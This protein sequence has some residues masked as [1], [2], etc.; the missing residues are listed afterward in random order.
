MAYK[1]QHFRKIYHN[2]GIFEINDKIRKLVKD[3][4]EEK[5]STHVCGYGYIDPNKGLMIEL[6]DLGKFGK[7]RYTSKKKLTDKSLSLPFSDVSDVLLS[8]YLQIP[9]EYIGKI[10]TLMAFNGSEQLEKTRQKEELDEFRDEQ[11][12][13]RLSVKLFKEGLEPEIVLTEIRDMTKQIYT[14]IL[15]QT[16]KQP[17]GL[18]KG[19]IITFTIANGGNRFHLVADLRADKSEELDLE[20]QFVFK[21]KINTKRESFSEDV[22]FSIGRSD[23]FNFALYKNKVAPIQNVRIYNRTLDPL[24]NLLIRVTSDCD[25]F[26]PCEIKIPFIQ[27]KGEYKRDIAPAIHNNP[28]MD[29]TESIRANFKIELL[30]DETKEE[31]CPPI[32]WVMDVLTYEQWPGDD[33]IAYLTAF[34]IPNHKYISELRSIASNYLKQHNLDPSLEGYQTNKQNGDPN[35]VRELAAACYAAVQKKDISYN[36]PPASFGKGQRIRTVD[37][38]LEERQGTCMDMTL[39]YASLL[40]SIDLHS[41][42]VLKKG[43]IFIGV[44]LLEKAKLPDP[45]VTNGNILLHDP[46]LF[47]IE[48]TKMCSHMNCSFEE[49]E[50]IARNNLIK[51]INNDEFQ[52]GVDV[53]SVRK[54]YS[55]LPVNSRKS[56]MQVILVED[57][58]DKVLTPPPSPGEYSFFDVYEP[59]KANGPTNKIDLWESKLINLSSS[60][61]L[62]NIGKWQGIQSEIYDQNKNNPDALRYLSTAYKFHVV[63]D[64]S[65]IIPLISCYLPEIEDALADGEEFDIHKQPFYPIDDSKAIYFKYA[66]DQSNLFEEP[67]WNAIGF[68]SPEFFRTEARS[69]RLY[70]LCHPDDLNKNLKNIYRKAREGEREYGMNSLYLALGVLRWFELE[71]EVCRTPLY[72][73]LI[74][75]PVDIEL[76]PG[77]L[78]YSL[79]QRTGKSHFNIALLEKLR[80]QYGLAIS[81]LDPL[82]VDDHGLDVA[83]IFAMVRGAIKELRGWDV[84]ETASIGIF[85]LKNIFMWNDIHTARNLL[86]NNKVIRSLIK[87]RVDWDTEKPHEPSDDYMTFVTLP[88]DA[89]QL[90]AIDYAGRGNTFVLHGP[91]GTGKSQTIAGMIGNALANHKTVLF[92]AQKETAL[93]VVQ[94]RLIADLG[95][96]DYCLALHS[97]SKISSILEQFE[98]TIAKKGFLNLSKFQGDAEKTNAL[99]KK[100]DI[101]RE[102]LHKKQHCGLTLHQLIDQYCCEDKNAPYITFHRENTENLDQETM[103]RQIPLIDQLISVRNG[104]D[105]AALTLL[106][107]IGISD[108]DGNV[109]SEINRMAEQY[110][111]A[112][113]EVIETG[114]QTSEILHQ[115]SP[116]TATDLILLSKTISEI[117]QLESIGSRFPD[118]SSIDHEAAIQ[119]YTNREK[120]EKQ[121]GEL[122]KVWTPEFLKKK[123]SIFRDKLASAQKGIF[124]KITGNNVRKVIKELE[125]YSH[126][127]LNEFEVPGLLDQVEAFQQ[128]EICIENNK[129]QLSR[130]TLDL[131]V[132]F[133][134][135]SAF[136]QVYQQACEYQQREK[137][138]TGGRN[139]ADLRN[140]PQTA[141]SFRSFAVAY[142][143]YLETKQKF[144]ETLKR[145]ETKRNTDTLSDEISL[146]R[147]ILINRN[148]VRKA[149]LYNQYRA[150]CIDAGLEPVVAAYENGMDDPDTLKTAYRKGLYYSLIQGIINSDTVMTHFMGSKFNNDIEH[151][152]EIDSEFCKKTIKELHRR[153]SNNL[154]SPLESHEIARQ[155]TTLQKAIKRGSRG[156]AL[157]QLFEQIPDILFRIFPCMLMC[158]ETVAQYLPQQNDLFDLVIFDE[159]S[160]METCDA[161]G[162]LYRGKDAVIVGDP[163]QMTPTRFFAGSGSQVVNPDIEDLGSI[164][165]EV[166]AI[167]IPSRFLKWHYRSAHESLIA[168]SNKNFYKNGMFTFPSADDR[169]RKIRLVPVKSNYKESVNKNEAIEIVKEILH[170]FTDPNTP[171]DHMYGV[172]AF[173]EQQQKQI[174]DLLQKQCNENRALHEW[175]HSMP[176]GKHE[177]VEVKPLEKVQGDEWDT[178][179]FSITF[180]PD[181]KGVVRQ[182]FGPINKD[183][184]G[185]RLNVA[186]SRARKEMLVYTGMRSSDIKTDKAPDGVVAFHDFLKFV[187]DL[188][189]DQQINENVGQKNKRNSETS[190]IVKQLCEVLETNGFACVP[191]IGSSDFRI[192]I[193]VLNPYDTTR[194]LLGIML[195]GDTYRMTENTKDREIAQKNLLEK[196]RGWK[197]F[198]IWALDWWDDREFVIEQLLTKLEKLKAAAAE[199]ASHDQPAQEERTSDDPHLDAELER[200]SEEVSAELKAEEER[201]ES[202]ASGAEAADDHKEI[203]EPPTVPEPEPE[204]ETAVPD[205]EPD[206]EPEAEP[207]PEQRS[208]PEAASGPVTAHEPGTSPISEPRQESEPASQEKDAP[209][210]D[211]DTERS[212]P[213]NSEE[214][215]RESGEDPES[216]GNEPDGKNPEKAVEEPETGRDDPSEDHQHVKVSESEDEEQIITLMGLLEEAG[217]EM[218]DKRPSGGLLWIIGGKRLKP[219]IARCKEIGVYF[220]FKEGGGKVCKG[221]DAW[222]TKDPDPAPI[223]KKSAVKDKQTEQTSVP[224]Q[225]SVSETDME[226]DDSVIKVNYAAPQSAAHSGKQTTPD[227]PTEP[228]IETPAAPE[229]TGSGAEGSY[230]GRPYFEIDIPSESLGWQEY[231]LPANK[232]E[233]AR[234][235]VLITEGEGVIERELLAAKLRNSFGVKNS[236]RVTEATEKAL[237]SAKIK[238]TKVKGIPYCWASDIDPKT[239][240]GFRYHE[241]TKRKDDELPLPEMRNAVVRTLM[242]HGPL[243]EDDLLF[244]TSRTF[245]YQRLGPNLKAR[246]MEGIAYAVSDKLIRLNKQK[247]YELR[248]G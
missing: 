46:R 5:D 224:Q 9:K 164:L 112:L 125:A 63:S 210:D 90:E 242:D 110:E 170:R 180:G 15:L 130:N 239:Y 194:Y 89:T 35:R 155:I 83:K 222:W 204:G 107:E 226:I 72:A 129:R 13:D 156:A 128:E 65:T 245:G 86:E 53:N 60:N 247:K 158:P 139:L 195:D 4:S 96:G 207:S 59:E 198:R 39:L 54:E 75:A 14:G 136:D 213:E 51:T 148:A 233:I 38:V 81:G 217:V 228:V 1:T 98:R 240:T 48:C 116:E 18:K 160:Q 97:K 184:G 121:R 30:N 19:A 235:A 52:F 192:D 92:V 138:L 191:H 126:R 61:K 241:E 165:D 124:G 49:A 123:T 40:E 117:S 167:S 181:E 197:I 45:V 100:L 37:R 132:Q 175:V 21:S 236:E 153:L 22:I 185:K 177:R 2:V 76:K 183:G 151:Y 62:L 87:Q 229:N 216:P 149:A 146:C 168:F 91:P 36:N 179:I 206:A 189:Q 211:G 141:D 27:V 221:R 82:P 159:A 182:N 162:A 56:K 85:D 193:G 244:Q 237:K 232:A 99:Q 28:L 157:R 29:L 66:A 55:I 6:L 218:I 178:V 223:V 111:S 135:V 150:A 20:P 57:L 84:I 33:Y 202:E 248:E 120:L 77:G 31:V 163:E 187:E 108:Y 188:N 144:N 230:Q 119:Y 69:H 68:T 93:D 122:L 80:Q 169:A 43:H 140:D 176:D 231:C 190:G 199:K 212:K 234:R 8:S 34:V 133:D 71:D 50:K 173:N 104:L 113:E 220:H 94:R 147:M 186:F 238:T 214:E 64:C 154:P 101:Y 95:I 115:K 200:Q 106:P 118:V 227:E 215:A 174:E 88:V 78:G 137:E 127:Q 41:V 225:K 219:L 44:W 152:K 172:I 17:F 142:E 114:K 161:I 209:S 105:E 58:D 24:K 10:D 12:P 246:L 201:A 3:Y 32:E 203:M 205:K 143:G 11:F 47:F 196:F 131:I 109:R 70:S 208:A 74:L 103:Q 42:L 67:D 102:H 16:P 166:L 25:I 243:P 79:H 73:P 134:N 171:S 23:V 7:T 145:P 26:E